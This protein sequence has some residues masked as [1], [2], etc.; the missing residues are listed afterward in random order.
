MLGSM[1]RKHVFRVV[2][3]R[4]KKNTSLFSVGMKQVAAD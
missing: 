4:F 3:G 2:F 1:R